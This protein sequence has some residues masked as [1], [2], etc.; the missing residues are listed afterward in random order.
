GYL[1]GFSV[2]DFRAVL[3]D[4]AYHTVDSSEIAFKIAGNLAFKAAMEHARP[5]LLEPIMNVS[6]ETPEE[7][8]GDIMGDLNSRRGRGQGMDTQA[9]TDVIRSRALMWERIAYTNT[10]NAVP[11]RR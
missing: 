1:A 3:Y 6:V 8:M 7:F 5:T 9:N 4:G 2:V 10:L 11:R